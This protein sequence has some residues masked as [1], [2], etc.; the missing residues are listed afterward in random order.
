VFSIELSSDLPQF[1]VGFPICAQEPSIWLDF[2]CRG[3]K[4]GSNS[5]AAGRS[6]PRP[7]RH[8]KNGPSDVLA[9]DVGTR[10]RQARIE[11]G[12]TLAEL[13][14]EELSRSF[15]SLVET[16]KTRISLRSL[17]YIAQRLQKPISY[18]FKDDYAARALA[19]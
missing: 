5:G 12:L 14:G 1:D 19:A 8:E 4:K 15:L 10:I 7:R 11:A 13:G 3:R 9:A 6:L 17:A 18:F 2:L 16:G